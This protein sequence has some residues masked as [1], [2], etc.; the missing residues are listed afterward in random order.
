MADRNSG[1]DSGMKI[2]QVEGAVPHSNM[3][4]KPVIRKLNQCD[5]MVGFQHPTSCATMCARLEALDR[6]VGD[7]KAGVRR[8][9]NLLTIELVAAHHPGGGRLDMPAAICPL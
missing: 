7:G 3:P 9:E 4:C 2:L 5:S 8:K 1:R 6:V